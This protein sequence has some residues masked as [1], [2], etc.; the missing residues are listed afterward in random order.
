MLGDPV[1]HFGT[2]ERVLADPTLDREGKRAILR[3]WFS[4]ARREVRT[5]GAGSES[6]RSNDIGRV[7]RCLAAISGTCT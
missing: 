3:R 2:P 1:A 7:A 6:E 4:E 5:K